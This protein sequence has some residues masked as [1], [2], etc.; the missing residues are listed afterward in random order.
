MQSCTAFQVVYFVLWWELLFATC[1]AWQSS[2]LLRLQQKRG[3]MERK[4]IDFFSPSK[5]TFLLLSLSL[6]LLFYSLT[7]S[8]FIWY[9][10]ID[11]MNENDTAAVRMMM[12]PMNFPITAHTPCVK[13]LIDSLSSHTTKSSLIRLFENILPC[14]LQNKSSFTHFEYHVGLTEIS[15]WGC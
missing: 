4:F 2:D 5:R 7:H 6:S 14:R 10:K 9:S 1:V 8:L 3:K 11:D 15:W 12:M 13:M